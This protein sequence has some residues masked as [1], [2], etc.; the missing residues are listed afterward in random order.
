MRP[1]IAIPVFRESPVCRKFFRK[2]RYI[3]GYAGI[4]AVWILSQLSLA[5][6]ERFETACAEAANLVSYKPMRKLVI[7]VMA[8]SLAGLCQVSLSASALFSSDRVGCSVSK[9]R[10]NCDEM[11][12]GTS[13]PQL[14]APED[15][16]CCFVSS[17]PAG[18]S[19]FVISN[20]SFAV[21]YSPSALSVGDAPR[22]R[23][24]S[25]NILEHDY[26]PP[27]SQSRLCIFLI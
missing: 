13:S 3:K 23:T 19:H 9:I 8:V 24:R 16:S 15:T 7:L 10:S 6:T 17:L 25:A 5:N 2:L 18:E 20:S 22:V 27:A 1:R 4:K 14:A 12:M 26:S 21:A 11:D